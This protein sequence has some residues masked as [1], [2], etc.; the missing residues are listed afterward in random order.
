MSEEVFKD[1]VMITKDKDGNVEEKDIDITEIPET[2]S[3]A[4]LCWSCSNAYPSKCPKIADL[5]KF[6]I[7]EY[8]FITSGY[9]IMKDDILCR[10]IV[11][12][13]SNFS[14]DAREPKYSGSEFRKELGVLFSAYYGTETVKEALAEFE[15]KNNEQYTKRM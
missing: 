11:L 2:N 12:D 9:Q 4:H 3:N 7:D 8:D 1:I 6:S 14:L 15:R 10:F 5:T 13:C